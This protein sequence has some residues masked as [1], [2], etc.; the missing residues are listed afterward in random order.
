MKQ[1]DKNMRNI[2]VLLDEQGIM[3][4]KSAVR[5]ATDNNLKEFVFESNKLITVYAKYLTEFLEGKEEV[6]Y[7][8]FRGSLRIP[9]KK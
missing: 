2:K 9:E 5:N 6:G 4:L 3:R 8:L 7:F 1:N